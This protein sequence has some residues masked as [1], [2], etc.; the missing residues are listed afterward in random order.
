MYMNARTSAFH[1]QRDVNDGKPSGLM[2][3]CRLNTLPVNSTS[4][5]RGGDLIKHE[6]VRMIRVMVG[7]AAQK[8][9]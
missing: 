6:A 3:G 9:E 1:R 7:Q 4:Q 8:M 2:N 5:G